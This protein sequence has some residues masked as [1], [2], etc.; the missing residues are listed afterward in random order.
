M[1]LSEPMPFARPLTRA[2]MSHESAP[3]IFGPE[4]R[5][6]AACFAGMLFLVASLVFWVA[7]VDPVQSAFGKLVAIA[8]DATLAGLITLV[9]WRIRAWPLGWKALT[10]CLLSL[11]AS[12]VSALI[13]WS[14]STWCMWPQLAPIVP[15]YVAQVVIFSTSELFGWSCLYLALQYSAELRDRERRLAALREEALSAQM[16]A[17]HYQI[18]PHFLFNT[19]NSIAGLVE[20]GANGP[21]REMALRLAGFLRRTISL[22]PMTDMALQEEIDL[23]RAYLGIEEARFSDRMTLSVEIDPAVRTVRVPAL[24]LQPLVENAVKHGIARTPGPATLQIGAG[25]AADGRLRLF[26]ENSVPVEGAD[27]AD[28]LGI[29]LAN[30]RNRL[31]ARFGSAAECR[32]L[33]SEP[34][35][36]RVEL[37]LP[38]SA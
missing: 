34:G 28:G 11:A 4:V 25:W 1:T 36:N 30:V 18:N 24:I 17:L 9:L 3:P 32:I 8:G 21:A 33:V 6:L 27:P 31:E 35:R 2:D 37:L 22:D 16:R 23:Q 38:V 5:V 12:P 10:A 19:L 7:G 15:A 14:I 20:E 26:V 13:D 29:G